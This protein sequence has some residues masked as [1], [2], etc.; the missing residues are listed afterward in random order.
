[1]TTFQQRSLLT[2]GAEALL[3]RFYSFSEYDQ[4]KAYR[5]TLHPSGT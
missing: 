5:H 1:M 4:Q 3:L 2:L